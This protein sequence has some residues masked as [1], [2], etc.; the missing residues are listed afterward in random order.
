MSGMPVD[1][2]ACPEMGVWQ[3]GAKAIL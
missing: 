1:D 2:T 3:H